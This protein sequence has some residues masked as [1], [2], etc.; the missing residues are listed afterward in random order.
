MYKVEEVQFEYGSKL[1]EWDS[2]ASVRVKPRRILQMEEEM[3]KVY[4]PKELVPIV[5]HPIILNLGEDA[6]IAQII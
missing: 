2:K 3:G 4:F 1:R 6:V 5:Q